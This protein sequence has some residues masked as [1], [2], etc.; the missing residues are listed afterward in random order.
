MLIYKP[1]CNGKTLSA[2][3]L[4]AK[5][6]CH[7]ATTEQLAFIMKQAD[8]CIIIPFG[9]NAT[10]ADGAQVLLFYHY[11]EEVDRSPR[12]QTQT[13]MHPMRIYT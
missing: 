3:H 1:A 9:T 2:F 12:L 6:A 10:V 7:D 4:C 11:S 13:I 5:D 8:L